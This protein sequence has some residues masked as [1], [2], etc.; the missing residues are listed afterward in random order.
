MRA[1]E[2][3]DVCFEGEIWFAAGG[4]PFEGGLLVL[5]RYVQGMNFV[6]FLDR[7]VCVS[8]EKEVVVTD[9]DAPRAVIGSRPR[10]LILS[11]LGQ[12]LYVR[13]ADTAAVIPPPTVAV[14]PSRAL[15]SENEEQ[16]HPP[17]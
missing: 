5:V 2:C 4:D 1:K 14:D 9:A 10:A 6:N 16:P 7:H 13:T 8:E 15:V 11:P 3:K 17:V 12:R